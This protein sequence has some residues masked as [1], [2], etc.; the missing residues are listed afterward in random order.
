MTLLL[1]L[2]GRGCALHSAPRAVLGA[3]GPMTKGKPT[4][5]TPTNGIPRGADPG[6]DQSAQQS[7]ELVRRVVD[8]AGDDTPVVVATDGE[9]FGHHH[10]Y[11]DRALAYA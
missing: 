7:Q 6:A 1:G 4:N 10:K 9:T 2:C 11:A 8:A 3:R 5:G